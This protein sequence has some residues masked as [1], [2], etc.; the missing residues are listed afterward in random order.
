M[1]SG[2]RRRI[3]AANSAAT[4]MHRIFE[5]AHCVPFL[6]PRLPVTALLIE[7]TVHQFRITN[8]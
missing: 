8:R 4:S 3:A 6:G 7:H 2:L 5:V 1:L